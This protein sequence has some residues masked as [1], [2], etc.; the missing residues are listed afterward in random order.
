MSSKRRN[1]CNLHNLAHEQ[2]VLGSVIRIIEYLPEIASVLESDYFYSKA[3]QLIFKTILNMDARNKTISV[4]TLND[5]LKWN[6]EFEKV[7]G[8]K[9]LEKLVECFIDSDPPLSYANSIQ[10]LAFTRKLIP[11]INVLES[12]CLDKEQNIFDILLTAKSKISELKNRY[13]HR[14]YDHIK[15]I[16]SNFLHYLE[17]TTEE[18]D[19][20]SGISV[21]PLSYDK[22]A[23][24]LT[25]S[26]LTIFESENTVRKTASL[27]DIAIKTALNEKNKGAI[28]VFSNENGKK[29]IGTRFLS[30]LSGIKYIKLRSGDLIDH[31]WDGLAYAIDKI[32]PTPIFINEAID[33]DIYRIV[34]ISKQL[35]KEY[36]HGV[37]LILV[38]NLHLLKDAGKKH[39]Y[40]DITDCLTS[41]ALKL[42][43]PVV[44][45]VLSNKNSNEFWNEQSKKKNSI[46]FQN[47]EAVADNSVACK[48]ES[49]EKPMIKNRYLK[50]V[51]SNRRSV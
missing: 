13:Q 48:K 10:K 23:S 14:Q 34:N 5:S 33:N 12:Q 30:Q 22:I 43:I 21:K 8:I 40:S 17:E 49:I 9:Y 20:P 7:G 28:L 50:L 4:I 46:N 42:Q 35:D 1:T 2:I 32:T 47:L 16:I 29:R 31:H 11:V 36:E 38:D 19:I 6:E 51:Y 37:S 25:P 15:D 18:I 44:A 26:E 27:L 3:H 24:K 45:M 39:E 41:L